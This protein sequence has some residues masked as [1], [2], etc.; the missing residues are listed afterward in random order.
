[1]NQT[2]V[3]RDIV[4]LRHI[5][6]AIG[7]I[8]EYASVADER[9]YDESIAE[10]AIVRQLEIICEAIRHVST[11]LRE[12]Q[13]EFTSGRLDEFCEQFEYHYLDFDRQLA[14]EVTQETVPELKRTV[15]A[16][17]DEEQRTRTA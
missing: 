2:M 7:R 16:I 17:L 8:E 9:L 13:P 12:R 1:M 3:N 11:E 6:D 10:D 14:W 15:E 5:W 4:R